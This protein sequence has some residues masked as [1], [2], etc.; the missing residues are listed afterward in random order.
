WNSDVMLNDWGM[1]T[2]FGG[3]DERKSDRLRK[4]RALGDE[5]AAHFRAVL[6]EAL[7]RFRHVIVLTHVPP[8]KEACWHEGQIS[9]DNWLPHFTCKAVGDVLKDAMASSDRQMT[10]Y[11]G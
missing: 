2:E 5:A 1:I 3:F 8:F 9:N 10:V 4:L 6:P 11:C 7:D